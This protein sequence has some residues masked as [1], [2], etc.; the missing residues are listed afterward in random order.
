[1]GYLIGSVG[2][3]ATAQKTPINIPRNGRYK[4]DSGDIIYR[5]SYGSYWQFDVS[6][7]I[8]ANVLV[9]NFST[10]N[11]RGSTLKGHGY[12]LRCLGR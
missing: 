1:M 12:S 7:E 5:P 4:H 8:N 2:L 10:L 3:D 6:S 9:F 11:P